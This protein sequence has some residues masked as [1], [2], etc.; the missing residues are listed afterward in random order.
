MIRFCWRGAAATCTL[1]SL[2]NEFTVLM[3]GVCK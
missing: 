1:K 3:S 2:L